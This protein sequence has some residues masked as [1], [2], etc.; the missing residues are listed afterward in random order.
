MTPSRGTIRIRRHYG[1][2]ERS[3]VDV[4]ARVDC[5]EDKPGEVDV[6]ADLSSLL[7]LNQR[8]SQKLERPNTPS[9]LIFCHG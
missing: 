5:S 3:K 7:E 4:D 6:D 1:K 9:I 2:D 8:V